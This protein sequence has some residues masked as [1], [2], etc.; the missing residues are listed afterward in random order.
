MKP[1][2]YKRYVTAAA[3]SALVVSAVA[4]V[5]AA[6]QEYEKEYSYSSILTY[7]SQSPFSDVPYYSN[8]HKLNII[9]AKELGIMTGYND[10]TFKPGQKLNRGNVVKVLGKYVVAKSGMALEEYVE[11]QNIAD[12]ENFIDVPD[13]WADS[14]LVTY[15]KIVKDAGI[16]KGS[17]NRLEAEKLMPR[18]QIAE[19]MVRAFDLQDKEGEPS[20]SYTEESAYAKSIEVI[21]ENGVSNAAH[22]YRPQ[23][24][25]SRGQF[26]SF[27]VRAY[28]VSEGLNPEDPYPFPVESFR[29]LRD[30]SVNLGGTPDLPETVEVTLKS[31]IKFMTAVE[32]NMENLVKDEIGSYKLEGKIAGSEKTASVTV[33]VRKP[34]YKRIRDIN[35]ED[36]VIEITY[37]QNISRT[38]YDP[39]NYR[40]NG[41]TLPSDTPIWGGRDGS[42][43][44]TLPK[45]QH[46][47]VADMEYRFEITQ[48]VQTED[49]DII[50]DNSYAANNGTE[51][52]VNVS[53]TGVFHDNVGPELIS[54]DYVIKTGNEETST[55]IQLTF[56]EEIA[57]IFLDTSHVDPEGL[58]EQDYYERA[59]REIGEQLLDDIVF[60][61]GGT[62][63][64]IGV[65][66]WTGSIDGEKLY[67]DIRETNINQESTITIIPEGKTNERMM[68]RDTSLGQNPAESPF[69]KT[70]TKDNVVIIPEY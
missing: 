8:S 33:N 57:P 3:A 52:P 39:A 25:T 36:N 43:K 62:E 4:P 41:E 34:E 2:T 32:W 9:D 68:I 44:I 6:P 14:E 55:E 59:N 21:L 12:I 42:V 18:D 22:N 50:V 29:A 37:P 67:L 65:W 26:A 63:A 56:S 47:I 30:V 28:K 49:G 19:V 31:G 16:F 13:D 53:V 66:N 46:P 27:I 70:I 51:Q 20:V 40:L 61:I 58:E 23:E 64:Y 5:A 10:G 15:S 17:N 7:E 54:A 38:A 45:P 48:N 60:K 11:S 1:N 24:A 69:T 35:I